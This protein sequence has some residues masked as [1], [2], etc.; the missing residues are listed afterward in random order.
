[1]ATGEIFEKMKL[2][3]EYNNLTAQTKEDTT[4]N[5]KRLPNFVNKIGCNTPRTIDSTAFKTL[6]NGFK[7][8]S[9]EQLQTDR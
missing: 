2:A 5:Q 8:Q 7:K 4:N 3:V 9:K 6:E 1:M